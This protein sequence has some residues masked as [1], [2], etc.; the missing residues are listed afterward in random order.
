MSLVGSS[1]IQAEDSSA[2]VPIVLVSTSL[3]HLGQTLGRGAPY[4]EYPKAGCNSRSRRLDRDPG[5][6]ANY[7][8]LHN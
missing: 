6:S 1:Q 7:G 4:L 5:S 3:H 8:S 2:A